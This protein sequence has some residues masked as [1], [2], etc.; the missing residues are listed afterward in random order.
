MATKKEDKN[1]DIV[2]DDIIDSTVPSGENNELCA[3]A[4]K[5]ITN[6]EEKVEAMDWKLWE[7]YNIIKN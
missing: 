7:I 1:G 2:I 6:I 5:S 4:V 3:I